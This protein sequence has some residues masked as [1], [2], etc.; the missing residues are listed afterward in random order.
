MG[1]IKDKKMSDQKINPSQYVDR[2]GLQKVRSHKYLQATV[3]KTGLHEDWVILIGV[4]LVFAFLALTPL[5]RSTIFNIIAVLY[6]AYKSFKALATDDLDDDKRWLTYWVTFG[7]FMTV[8]PVL[9][10]ITDLFP[11]YKFVKLVFFVWMIH[12]STNGYLQV[13]RYVIGPL[14]S[15]FDADIQNAIE[16]THNFGQKL[17]AEVHKK[18]GKLLE[19]QLN[20]AFATDQVNQEAAKSKINE[21]L[22]EVD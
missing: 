4:G 7:F 22:N 13:F 14:I 10:I 2:L 18:G 16:Q 9:S 20:K 6:P 3:E 12:G 11:Y 21:R 17:G 8:E 1:N 5:G 19:E 15:Q